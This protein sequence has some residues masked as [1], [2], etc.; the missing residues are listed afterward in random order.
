LNSCNKDGT[1]DQNSNIIGEWT[2][3]ESVGG[4]GGWTINPESANS[5][6]KLIIDNQSYKEYEND[7]LILETNYDLIIANS[8]TFTILGD[9]ILELDSGWQY[10]LTIQGNELELR[11]LCFDCFDHRYRRN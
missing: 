4:F 10:R 7:T 5:T 8:S 2:W 9:S 11:E 3:I 6:R 1:S